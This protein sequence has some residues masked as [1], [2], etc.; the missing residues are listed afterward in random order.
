MAFLNAKA[1]HAVTFH[2]ARR[3]EPLTAMRRCGRYG[4]EQMRWL[5][6]HEIQRQL[7]SV[8]RLFGLST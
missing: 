1:G 7:R 2:I 3:S 6:G 5:L 4:R 8:N